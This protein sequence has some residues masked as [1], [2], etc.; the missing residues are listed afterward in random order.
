MLLLPVLVTGEKF[1]LF[2]MEQPHHITLNATEEEIR[3][4]LV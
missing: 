3:E 2:S 4:K 1:L